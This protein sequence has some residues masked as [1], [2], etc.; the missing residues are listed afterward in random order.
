ML[1]RFW[2]V[3]AL[4]KNQNEID[5]DGKHIAI[6]KRE[7]TLAR[8]AQGIMEFTPLFA[9]F[10][11]INDPAAFQFENVGTIM[12]FLLVT[13]GVVLIFVGAVVLGYLVWRIGM[14]KYL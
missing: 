14:R 9:M 4:N 6:S 11:I 8:I 3:L 1:K 10:L 7:K 13:V 12:G 2:K 5:L